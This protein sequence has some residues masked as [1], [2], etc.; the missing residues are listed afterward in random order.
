MLSTSAA[1]SR[2]RGRASPGFQSSIGGFTLAIHILDDQDDHLRGSLPR[3][4]RAGD[5]PVAGTTTIIAVR[6]IWAARLSVK[7][8]HVG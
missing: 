6:L 4:L 7:V 5:S 2:S 8:C 1:I 3:G